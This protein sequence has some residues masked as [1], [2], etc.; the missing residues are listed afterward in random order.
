MEEANEA[1]PPPMPQAD[2]PEDADRPPP[3]N[4]DQEGDQ[5]AAAEPMEDEASGGDAAAEPMEDN[6]APSAT[7]AVDDSTI[8]GKCRRHKKKF[9]DMVPTEGIRVLHASPLSADTTTHLTGI[10]RR[11]RHLPTNSSLRLARELDSE[12]LIALAA[13]LPADTLSEDKVATAVLPRI[14]L[15]LL[16][17]A[18]RL[19]RPPRH[20]GEQR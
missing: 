8:V 18:L 11:R 16:R 7:A 2:A 17:L 10:P 14:F 4:M 15:V 13:G 19:L 5:A 20:G 6:A 3:T 1:Q 12:A 9:L